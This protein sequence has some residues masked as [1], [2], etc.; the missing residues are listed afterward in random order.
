MVGFSIRDV[1]HKY[2]KSKDIG[3]IVLNDEQIKCVQAIAIEMYKDIMN[4]CHKYG[5]QVSLSGGSALGAVRHHGFIPWD[6]DID[7]MMPRK[8]YDIFLKVA[9][10]ELGNKYYIATPSLRCSNQNDIILRVLNKDI[11]F[12]DIFYK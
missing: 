5:L 7:L 12:R 6:D 9:N 2:E 1:A 8:D 10:D 11:V 4:V 3:L